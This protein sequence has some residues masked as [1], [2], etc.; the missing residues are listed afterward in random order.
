MT[1]M[2]IVA[3]PVSL[4]FGAGIW[5]SLEAQV[6]RQ[7]KDNQTRLRKLSSQAQMLLQMVSLEIESVRMQTWSLAQSQTPSSQVSSAPFGKILYWAEV[8]LQP[9]GMIQAKRSARNP[10][11]S[12]SSAVEESFLKSASQ[13]FSL[14]EIQQR[15]VGTLRMKKD[16]N[17]GG[18]WLGLAFPSLT[19][20]KSLFL[21]LIDPALAFSSFQLWSA[22]SGN[23]QSRSYLI[24]RDGRVLS[25]SQKTF[26]SADFSGFS[27]FHTLI[28]K[29]L[30]GAYSTGSGDFLGVDQLPVGVA[31]QRLGQLPLAVVVEELNNQS[32]EYGDEIQIGLLAL[33]A[34]A[35]LGFLIFGCA[36]ILRSYLV[37]VVTLT[38]PAP[39]EEVPSHNPDSRNPYFSG[40]ELL[41]LDPIQMPDD[42]HL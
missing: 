41:I 29:G 40:D 36:L 24:G 27:L 7:Q 22:H 17:G 11:W 1:I 4:G 39:S 23:G 35:V 3:V 10:A 14:Q 9:Q 6:S 42:T 8:E 38:V 20:Q 25:H 37:K 5:V 16:L 21:T 12:G 26:N 2:M 15:G 34:W 13:T 31:F 32:M 33:I 18:E 28:R 19:S 30:E